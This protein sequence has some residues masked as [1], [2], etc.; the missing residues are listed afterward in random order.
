MQARSALA[1]PQIFPSEW[2]CYLKVAHVDDRRKATAN[3]SGNK[4]G[5]MNQ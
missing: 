4:C 5:V 1:D 3:E 2:G